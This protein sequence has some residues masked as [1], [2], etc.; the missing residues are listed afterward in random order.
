[1]LGASCQRV[2]FASSYGGGGGG[3]AEGCVRFLI[4]RWRMAVVRGGWWLAVVGDRWL[5]VVGDRWR[6]QYG[7]LEGVLP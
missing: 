5:A 4:W 7:G 6:V 1:L 2:V 3:V